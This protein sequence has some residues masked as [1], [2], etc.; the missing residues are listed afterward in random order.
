VDTGASAAPVCVV[1][2]DHR[3]GWAGRAAGQSGCRHC[4]P[5]YSLLLYS[6][7]VRGSVWLRYGPARLRASRSAA[8]SATQVGPPQHGE[9][10]WRFL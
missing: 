1:C 3:L 4:T 8:G 6:E 2:E 9:Q 7:G 5:P 10:N